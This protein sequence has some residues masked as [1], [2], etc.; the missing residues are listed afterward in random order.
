MPLDNL[1]R[2]HASLMQC[3]KSFFIL[4]DYF[5]FGGSVSHYIYIYICV[6]IVFLFAVGP[7]WQLCS[8]HSDAA[9]GLHIS[10]QTGILPLRFLT[11]PSRPS[12]EA[13][14]VARKPPRV[15]RSLAKGHLFSY[16]MAVLSL[17][18]KISNVFECCGK[19][20]GRSSGAVYAK[21]RPETKIGSK[22]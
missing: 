12:N 10:S 21:T 16:Q 14:R 17:A 18:P 20:L 8:C 3:K 7:G 6:C 9:L 2:S 15:L 4:T 22:P 1:E 11:R 19:Q 13:R 5:V